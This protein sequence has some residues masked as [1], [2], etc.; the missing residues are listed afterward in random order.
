MGNTKAGFR[1]LREQVGYSQQ[2]LA[3]AMG[4]NVRSVKRWE[5]EGCPYDA[6]AD[7][8]E[9]LEEQLDMQRRMTAYVVETAESAAKELGKDAVAIPITYYRDQTM[10]DEHGRD[11]GY[12]G[13]ANANARAA[14]SALEQ[15]GFVVEYR[16][17]EEGAVRTP[18]SRY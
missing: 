1:A 13:V 9:L 7:A 15:R 5:H 18:D 17:P 4:V 14:G 11:E 6:P 3:D 16:Y 10:Y 8:W 12:F 2:A